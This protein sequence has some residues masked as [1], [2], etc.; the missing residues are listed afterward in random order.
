MVTRPTDNL[1]AYHFVLKGR[2]H[3]LRVTGPALKKGL[4]C[5]TQA[6]AIDPAYAQAHAGI[7]TVQTMRAMLS[8]AVPQQVMPPA[9]DAARKALE[10][11]ETVADAHFAL[12]MV[13]HWY[14]WNWEEAE[15]GYRRAL[16]LKPGDS[17]CRSLLAELL[18]CTGRADASIP[19]ARHAV[20]SDPGIYGRSCS[21]IPGTTG[22]R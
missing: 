10:I 1:E 14:E 15:L 16:D 7:A 5:F 9:G 13:R 3:T 17:L 2:F 21:G 12:A 4:E 20:E 8:F 22:S 19:E 18:V 11:D 6:L